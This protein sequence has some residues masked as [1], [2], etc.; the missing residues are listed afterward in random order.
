MSSKKAAASTEDSART[1]IT[2]S[3]YPVENLYPLFGCCCAV[4]SCYFGG[5]CKC[6]SYEKA[7]VSEVTESRY[8][9]DIQWGCC[10]GCC[11]CGTCQCCD[12]SEMDCFKVSV[13]GFRYCE[14]LDASHHCITTSPSSH[15]ISA[16][17]S[18]R[19][20]AWTSAVPSLSSQMCHAFLP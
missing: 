6:C 7:V 16:T 8:L 18:R 14:F 3:L 20:V 13:S 12:C 19:V 4:L 2:E 1:T 17:T 11:T 10:R 5:P 15:S 9:P